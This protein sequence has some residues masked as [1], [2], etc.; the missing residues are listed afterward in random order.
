MTARYSGCAQHCYQSR[1]RTLAQIAQ[2]DSTLRAF[3]PSAR[4][5]VQAARQSPNAVRIRRARQWW[6]A[7]SAASADAISASSQA[8][9]SKHNPS[10]SFQAVLQDAPDQI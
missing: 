4:S 3:R 8:L 9:D 1:L 7:A 10:P 5:A 6:S 2:A